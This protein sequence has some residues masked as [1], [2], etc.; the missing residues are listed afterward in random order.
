M[1]EPSANSARRP[2]GTSSLLLDIGSS[3]SCEPARSLAM[4]VNKKLGF[5]N[6]LF[7][8]ALFC[9]AVPIEMTHVGSVASAKGSPAATNRI[10]QMG[11]HDVETVAR[12]RRSLTE[13]C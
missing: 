11:S 1:F 4:S 5:H 3:S 9:A 12:E 8:N 7:E 2:Q 10:L 13:T 6:K